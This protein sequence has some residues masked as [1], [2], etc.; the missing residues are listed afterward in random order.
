MLIVQT[1]GWLVDEFNV[2]FQHKYGY[3]GDEIVQTQRM[4][5]V[6]DINMSSITSF[7]TR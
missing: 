5:C 1:V 3:I 7:D 6:K 4:L 2:P